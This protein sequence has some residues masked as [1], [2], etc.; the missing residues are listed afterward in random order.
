MYLKGVAA[1]LAF[2][3]LAAN[4]RADPPGCTAQLSP[5]ADGRMLNHMLYPQV[6]DMALVAAP[7]ALQNRHCRVSRAMLA[8]LQALLAAAAAEPSASGGIIAKSCFRSRAEQDVTFCSR[9]GVDERYPDATRRAMVSA[10]PGYSEHATGLAIDF[11]PRRKCAGK[12]GDWLEPCYALTAEGRWLAANAP[13]FGFEMSFPSGNAQGV[14]HEP[15]HWRWVGRSAD[16]PG[17]AAA[18]ALF[19]VARQTWPAQPAQP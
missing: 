5:M 8:D 19:A 4:A 2:S 15:W 11:R 18:R 16:V 7:K 12:S 6:V 13:R 3:V 10:P 17:A 1:A 14:A 9:I